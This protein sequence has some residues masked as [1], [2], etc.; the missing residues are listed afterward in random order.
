[1]SENVKK[2]SFPGS[3]WSANTIELFE[4]AAFY[5]IASF[6]VIYFHETLGM[7]P[8]FATFLN[9]TLLWGLVYFLPILSGTL[10]DRYGFKRSLSVSFVLIA[11][12]YFVLGT[13]Q[14]FWPGF[15][16][17]DAAEKVDYTIPVVLG[18]ILIG[19]G[20]SIVKPCIAGT[21]QKTSGVNATLG[22]GIFYMVIN[23]GSMTGRGVSYF[24]R[25]NLGIPAIF[26]YVATGF[27]LIGLIVV[28]FVY[29]EPQ[30]VSDG[31]KDEQKVERKTLGQALIGMVTVLTNLKFLFF[32]IVIGF[33]WFIYIQVYNLIP[34]FLR[35]L[36]PDAPVEIYTLA[37][38]IMI[39]MFQLL[40]TKLTKKWSSLKA[41]MM[42]ILVTTAGMLVNVLPILLFTDIT[43]KVSI[44]GILFPIA[45]IF[46]LLS[47]ASMAVGEMM[48]ASRQYEYI[49]ALAPK[50]QEG[51]F[52]GYANLPMAFGTLVGAP[53]G[54]LMYEY[55][56]ETPHKNGL[57]IDPM[58][59]WILVA[60][61][62]VVSMVGLMIYNRI[63]LKTIKEA[64]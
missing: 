52:L 38:P 50:G 39:V 44:V 26:T 5:A 22:F 47:F 63:M 43:R 28:L 27:A 30:F 3:F 53:I 35:Y 58:T 18:I 12:G 6:V 33:Y 13:V 15:I 23:V 51:L 60:A 49:G 36:D 42:G 24:A 55:F 11:M 48:L 4:R 21:V 62:G 25:V 64:A 1:M 32:L 31:K 56:I 54:G 45:T 34:L 2:V 41:I 20:G 59:M 10:A 40:I 46:V 9:G 16:G 61:M 37:N 19:I 57:P 14:K 8:A 29:K 17:A 7:R